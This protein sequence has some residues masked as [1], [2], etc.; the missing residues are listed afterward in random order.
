MGKWVS[1]YFNDVEYRKLER[2]LER[3]S[4][5]RGRKISAYELLKEWVVSKLKEDGEEEAK[6]N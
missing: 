5:R 1:I 3:E 6:P 2:V 4:R